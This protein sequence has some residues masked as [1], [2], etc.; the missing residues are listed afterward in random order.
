MVID[1]SIYAQ[2]INLTGNVELDIATEAGKVRN[3]EILITLNGHSLTAKAG[4]WLT[5]WGGDVSG[6]KILLQVRVFGTIAFAKVTVLA[7]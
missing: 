4:S 5:D 1:P 6:T 7:E 3:A 2:E